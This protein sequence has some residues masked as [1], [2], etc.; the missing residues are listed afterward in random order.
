MKTLKSILKWLFGILFVLIIGLLIYGTISQYI[1]D[2]NVA[3]EFEPTGNFAE[4]SLNKMHY[5]LIGE[6]DITFVL[7]TGLGENMHTWN[8]IQDS[9][10]QM[11]RVF[12]Y[13]RSGLGFSEANSEPRTTHQ[14]ALELNELL[15]TEKIPGPYV[16]VGHSI[17]GAHIR[18]FSHLFPQDVL[19]LFLIDASHEKMKDD[20][21]PPPFMEKFFNYSAVNLSWSGIPY[22]MLPNPPH[23]LYKTSKSIKAFGT[24]IVAI[25]TSIEQFKNGNVDNS[26]LPIYIISATSQDGD[27]KNRNLAFMEE[28]ISHSNSEIKKH[29]IY[30]KPHQI[31]LTDPEIVIA[32]LRE[33]T[34]NL[35]RVYTLAYQY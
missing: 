9:L 11:G 15:T 20:L 19:G 30:D 3:K 34:N 14:I 29:V 18:Y 22:Y 31:H 6:G 1:Y 26:A 17:G 10:A 21:P 12:M 16:L 13:D 35:F 27:F 4:L 24:E 5:K 33:F 32:G 2:R 25:D 23:P 8:K 7:E 28:L